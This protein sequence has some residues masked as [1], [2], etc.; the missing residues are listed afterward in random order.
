MRRL[1]Q[2]AVRALGVIFEV[3]RQLLHPRGL[4]LEVHRPSADSD[5]TL[6][7]MPVSSEYVDGWR[8]LIAWCREQDWPEWAATFDT[9]E[10]MLDGA[11]ASPPA[12]LRIQDHRDDPE[13]VYF[14]D[15][16]PEDR[17][18]AATF[19]GMIGPG[20]EQALGYIVEPLD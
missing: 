14:G 20:R 15:I 8:R 2:E 11:E 7:L 4:A 19:A 13:G 6:Y 16:G 12:I 18:K 17:V 1:D 9:L 3:N 5:P 10:E